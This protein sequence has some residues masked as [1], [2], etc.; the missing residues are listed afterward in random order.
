MIANEKWCW[1]FDDFSFQILLPVC[2]FNLTKVQILKMYED[3]DATSQRKISVKNDADINAMI[4][5]IMIM[6]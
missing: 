6:R 3:F 1:D 2:N 5:I 4:T